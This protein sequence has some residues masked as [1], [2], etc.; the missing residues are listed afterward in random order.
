M[1]EY[2]VHLHPRL[3]KVWHKRGQPE[4]N[5]MERVWR[6]VKDKLSCHRWWADWE[7]LWTATQALLA[8][9]KARFP[10]EQGHALEIAQDFTHPLSSGLAP[11]LVA[12]SMADRK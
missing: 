3:A 6:Y 11:K 7:A 5:L 9:L 4:L 12:R 1:D 10:W 2:E 8:R